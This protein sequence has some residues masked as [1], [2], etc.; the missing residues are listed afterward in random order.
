V[1]RCGTLYGEQ[2]AGS[3][4]VMKRMSLHVEAAR[5]LS[6]FCES[7]VKRPLGFRVNVSTG[8]WASDNPPLLDPKHLL[9]HQDVHA[10]GATVIVIRRSSPANG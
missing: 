2:F 10:N 5:G 8:M 6:G 4:Q 1:G 9:S 7:L 3:C